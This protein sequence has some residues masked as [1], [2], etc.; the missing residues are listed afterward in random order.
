MKIVIFGG[1]GFIGLH[2]AA[3][4]AG[5][6]HHLV[7]PVRDRERA[8]SLILL[9][10]IDVIAYDPSAT[11]TMIPHLNGADAVVNLCGVLNEHERN[12]F[13]RVHNEFVR[14]LCDGCSSKKVHRFVQI[15]AI[16]AASGASSEYLRSKAKAEQLVQNMSPVR[17]VII[18]PSV[19]FGPGDSFVN[20]FVKLAKFAPIMPLPCGYSMMQPISVYDLVTMI[21]HALES[22]EED[23]KIL[24]AGGP[25]QLMLVDI[26]RQALA[27][28]GTRRRVLPL[29]NKLSY[30]AAAIMEAIPGVYMLSRD[31]CLSANFPSV[32]QNNDAQRIVG[33]LTKLD[34]G[35]AHMFQRQGGE[36][37]RT[38][39]RR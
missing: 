14:I 6:G 29:G 24:T 16:N 15:S 37:L 21:V 18:R 13:V 7:L 25:E 19:V 34:A 3:A 8:K 20:L 23:E 32:T 12:E 26:V 28:A 31:N 17:W 9:P 35:L 5:R 38:H 30:L 36:N 1:N 4:L 2:L 27:A 22:G 33:D 39:L 11:N 10:N